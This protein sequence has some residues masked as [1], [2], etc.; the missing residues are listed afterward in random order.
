[1]SGQTRQRRRGGPEKG[2][3]GQG[4]AQG[5]AQGRGGGGDAG[6]G[7]DGRT[8]RRVVA[9]V[10]RYPSIAVSDGVNAAC[11]WYAAKAS[12]DKGR[13]DVA[14]GMGVVALAST[15]G[16][17]RFGLAP[18]TLA[19]ANSLWAEFAGRVGIPM[20]GLGFARSR[21]LW[22][23]ILGPPEDVGFPFDLASG[24]TLGAVASRLP[25][26]SP[27]MQEVYKILVGVASLG[28]VL[29]AEGLDNK[30]A[31]AAVATFAT[32]GL[33]VGNDRHRSSDHGDN[34]RNDA[35]NNN[36]N[37][38]NNNNNDNGRGEGALGDFDGIAER[39]SW[40]HAEKEQEQERN[41]LCCRSGSHIGGSDVEDC[42][43]WEPNR[44]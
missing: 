24:V 18:R 11:C 6:R 7:D 23:A 33:L 37:D 14:M 13:V 39:S 20:L 38:N 34:V 29:Y 3:Q 40:E 1:M 31:L 16:T 44:K 26:V 28:C 25:S 5:A 27:V 9:D 43:C 12:F 30:E 17:L 22:P 41:T 42:R 19:E 35:N 8:P 15:I 32:A 36:N 10:Q 21:G 2:Q 4:A